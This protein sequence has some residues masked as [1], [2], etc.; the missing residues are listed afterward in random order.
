MLGQNLETEISYVGIILILTVYANTVLG[1][2]KYF[3]NIFFG[4][5]FS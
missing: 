3:K 2:H 1:Q 4:V 5:V